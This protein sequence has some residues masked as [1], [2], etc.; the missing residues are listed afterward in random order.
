[1]IT[2]LKVIDLGKRE[3]KVVRRFPVRE[4]APY[5]HFPSIIMWQLREGLI[6]EMT[7]YYW[8]KGQGYPDW[9][10]CLFLN[11][12]EREA[13][14]LEPNDRMSSCATTKL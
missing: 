14:C 12:A 1:M 3:G 2:E 8:L 5:S 13:L 7:A 11:M 10:I 4:D 9:I 6:T